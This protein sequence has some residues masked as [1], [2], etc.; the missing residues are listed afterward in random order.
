MKKIFA[1]LLTAAL[2][3]APGAL[4]EE[5]SLYAALLDLM[6]GHSWTVTLEV[7]DAALEEAELPFETASLSLRAEEDTVL[8]EGNL[9]GE[10]ALNAAVTSEGFSYECACIIDGPQQWTWDE[11]PSML[12]MEKK[13]DGS[14]SLTGR[15]MGVQHENVQ[16]SL[17]MDGGYPGDYEGELGVTLMMSSGEI[18]GLWDLFRAEGG[19][20]STEFLISLSH[21]L[22]LTGEGTETYETAEN[23]HVTVTRSETCD[24]TQDGNEAGSLTLKRTVTME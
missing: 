24:V 23:G 17:E 13:D 20:S 6:D 19:E 9:D 14:W 12:R 3:Y 2:L 4:A 21:E 8:I 11:I 16:I 10:N 15:I 22:C 18:Y 7:T 1:L 5:D